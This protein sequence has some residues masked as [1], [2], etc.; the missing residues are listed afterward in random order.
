MRLRDCILPLFA[1]SSIT[2]CSRPTH[3]A[4]H[5]VVLID[6]S[7][8]IDPK[9]ESR[10]FD[11]IAKLG[12]HLARGDR[13]SVVPITGDAGNDSSDRVLRFSAP[14]ERQAYDEDL[15]RFAKTI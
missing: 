11:A 9:S 2:A 10:A 14:S 15:K 7:A 5:T 12:S 1:L 6:V 3:T 4:Q 8:S 13:L